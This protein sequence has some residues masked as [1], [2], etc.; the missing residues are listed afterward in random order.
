MSS[1]T[2]PLPA[3]EPQ[4]PDPIVE[5]ARVS[6]T[7]TLAMRGSSHPELKRALA[8]ARLDLAAAIQAM[9]AAFERVESG[10]AE[11]L[12]VNTAMVNHAAAMADL[13]RGE[14]ASSDHD[15]SSS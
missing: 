8:D 12:A 10:I 11:Q 13:L 15:Q 1:T 14:A 3:T 9:D 7:F 6:A 4:Q 5:A 2:P